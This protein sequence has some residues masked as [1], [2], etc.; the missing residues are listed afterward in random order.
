MSDV[1]KDLDR[2]NN[3]CVRKFLNDDKSSSTGFA[4]AYHGSVDWSSSNLDKQTF[5]QI[6]DCHQIIK[7]H[8]SESDTFEDFIDKMKKLKDVVND[9]IVYLEKEKRL[10]DKN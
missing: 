7:L 5:L 4:I 8:R 1:K 3:Y 10:N 9:F 2:S 6:G